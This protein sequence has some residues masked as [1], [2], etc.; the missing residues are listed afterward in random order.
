VID[1]TEAPGGLA[2]MLVPFSFVALLG[3]PW[4]RFVT[5]AASA[6]LKNKST[7]RSPCGLLGGI[8]HVVGLAGPLWALCR[9]S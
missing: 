7:P 2:L 6:A 9:P 8:W 1:E 5:P 3:S 4:I